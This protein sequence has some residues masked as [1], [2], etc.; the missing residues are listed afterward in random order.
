MYQYADPVRWLDSLR[1]QYKI[2]L[3][4]KSEHLFPVLAALSG[5]ELINENII[6]IGFANASM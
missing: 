4:L 6:N 5:K 3:S 2:L 1:D